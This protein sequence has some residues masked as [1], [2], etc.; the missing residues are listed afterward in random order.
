M[1]GITG[2]YNFKTMAP[3]ERWVIEDMNNAM[4]HRGPDGQGIFID[5]EVGLGH[6]RLSIIDLSSAGSQPLCNEDESIWLTFNGEIYNYIELVPELQAKGHIFKSKT[7]SEVIIHAYEEWGIDCIH[8]FNGMFGFAIWDKNRKRLIIARDRLGVK[9]LYYTFNN[10]GI[11]FA[12]EIK[13]ILKHPSY[14]NPS[15]DNVA[16]YDYVNEGYLSGNRTL[17]K[18]IFKLVPGSFMIIENQEVKENVYWKL[19]P[20]PLDSEISENEF[21]EQFRELLI[22]SIKIRLR[23]DVPVGFQLSGGIDSSAIVSVASKM[24]NF[25]S[26]TFSIRF[27]ESPKFDEGKFIEIVKNDSKTK[28]KELI[29]DLQTNFPEKLRE[30]IY[31]LDEPADGPA[32]LSKFELNKFLK[33]NGIT[34]ALTGQ[35]AD[36]I[37][38]GY[39]R[40]IHE[41]IKDL[42]NPAVLKQFLGNTNIDKLII[43]GFDHSALVMN[44]FSDV[45]CK[46]FKYN[47]SN[48][49]NSLFSESVNSMINDN[50]FNQNFYRQ[51]YPEVFQNGITNV[52]KKMHYETSFYL[53]SL[54][55]ADDRTSMGASMETRTPFVDYRLVELTS[56][57]P[58]CLKLKNLSTKHILRE[59][60]KGILPEPIRT[61]K[62]K[63]GFPTPASMWF[64]A[65]QKDYLKDIINSKEFI[66]RDIFNAKYVNKLFNE[67]Q[68]GRDHTFKLWFILNSEIWFRKFI[69]R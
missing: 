10:D 59:S 21:I 60:M 34:V 69:D 23:S 2:I 25:D 63:L 3:A 4:L 31:L 1:C 19:Q 12:S 49:K 16:I 41:H 32:V 6:R 18:D 8:K 57:I 45:M 65:S 62:D 14:K 64:R 11:I 9:P 33:N 27:D 56:K 48:F 13:A 22:D 53:Q 37:L 42:K 54:L 39:K 5:N 40:F 67:H 46:L 30:I 28:H 35:G 36:E 51:M 68:D 15:S 26:N 20:A 50:N 61:R 55:H 58:G 44:Q 47:S 7:D 52:S 24:L 17:F 38:G 29:P 43:N 66:D